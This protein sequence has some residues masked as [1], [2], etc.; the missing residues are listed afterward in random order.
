MFVARIPLVP[1]T[2]AFWCRAIKACSE[3]LQFVVFFQKRQRSKQD[4]VE[5]QVYAQ[6]VADHGPFVL[7][8]VRFAVNP[9]FDSCFLYVVPGSANRIRLWYIRVSLEIELDANNSDLSIG[10][11]SSLKGLRRQNQLSVVCP[12]CVAS[13]VCI[14]TL[15]TRGRTIHLYDRWIWLG[16]HWLDTREPSMHNQDLWCALARL[17]KPFYVKRSTSTCIGCEVSKLQ[18]ACHLRLLMGQVLLSSISTFTHFA[19]NHMNC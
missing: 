6:V 13:C 3:K 1:K 5:N 2:T 11:T 7:R 17:T 9:E 8:D 16:R 12:H 14:G 19:S 18:R 10:C 15:G 4:D